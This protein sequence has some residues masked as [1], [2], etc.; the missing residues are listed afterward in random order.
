VRKAKREIVRK[1]P[2][3]RFFFGNLSA[4][5]CVKNRL[6]FERSELATCLAFEDETGR[7]KDA[8]QVFCS[9]FFKKS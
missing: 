8:A 6:L 2:R 3:I 1:Q 5:E 7:Q 9:T 4:E